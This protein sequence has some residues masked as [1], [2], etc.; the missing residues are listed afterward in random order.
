METIVR[1][2]RGIP[3]EVLREYLLGLGGQLQP[4]G[5]LVGDGWQ[6]RLTRLP[7]YQ[8]GKAA[9]C[10]YRFELEGEADVLRELWPRFEVR[11]LR[12]GG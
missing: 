6:A 5:G 7:D 1:E 10:N 11:I 8:I 2:L 3:E 9:F 4:D 12:P